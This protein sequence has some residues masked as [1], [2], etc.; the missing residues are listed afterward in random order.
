MCKKLHEF[1]RFAKDI[2]SVPLLFQ[3]SCLIGLSWQL[4]EITS[5]Y[6]RYKVNIQ[7]T[8]FIPE[9]VEDMSMSLCLPIEYSI[10]YNKFHNELQYNWTVND[11]DRKQRLANLSIHQI[12]NY[13]YNA[14]NILYL[15]SYAE[16]ERRRGLKSSNFSSIMKMEKYFFDSNICYLYSFRFFK[17]LSVDQLRGGNVVFLTFGEQ[18]SPTVAVSLFIA[19]KDRIPFRETIKAP[20][21]FRGNPTT[22]L[23]TF[24][25]SYYTIRKELLPPPYETVCFSYSKLNFTNSVECVERCVVLKCFQK[26]GAISSG[27]LLPNKIKDYKFLWNRN[28][29]KTNTELNE[30]RRSCQSFCPNTSCEDTHIVTIQE[31]GVHLGLDTLYKN[32]SITWQKKTPSFPSTRILC[33]A[34]STLT[35]LILYMMSSVSTWTGLSMM[36]I[37]PTFILHSLS[38]IKLASRILPLQHR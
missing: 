22:K 28:N 14:D 1:L 38:K 23:D 5:E 30:I 13:T 31:S 21:T 24:Q 20:Y 4:F 9:Q 27:S 16:N 37:N 34:T 25:S 15:V 18:I 7:T 29:T 8:V 33:R 32:V 6:L 3:V 26:W 36:S 10:D 19:E 12:Y 17:P 35:E 11:L 2:V